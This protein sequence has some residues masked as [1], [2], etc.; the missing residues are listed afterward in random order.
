MKLSDKAQK[1]KKSILEQFEFGDDASLAILD[2]A[3]EAF[4]LK[5][6]AMAVV[7]AEGMTVQGDRGGVKAHPLLATIRDAQSQFLSA[8]KQLKLETDNTATRGPGRPTYWEQAKKNKR[9]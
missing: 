3:M 2:A 9:N 5:H 1:L 4:D 8:M 7:Q 6:S